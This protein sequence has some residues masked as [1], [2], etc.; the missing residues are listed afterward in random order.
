MSKSPWETLVE[1]QLGYAGFTPELHAAIGR[2]KIAVIGAGGNGAALDLLVRS[3]FSRFVI[4]DPG[5]VND[6]SL[7]R[8]PFN[9]DAIGLPKVE[10]WRKHLRDVNPDCEIRALH[11]GI[12]RTDAAFL[13][14]HLKGVSLILLGTT[15]VEAN[16]VVS[17]IA[18]RLGIR[19]II[20]PVSYGFLVTTTFIHDNGYSY[21][22][23]A[24]FETQDTPLEKIDYAALRGRFL[25]ATSVPGFKD[26]LAPGIWEAVLKGK[27]PTRSCSFLVCLGNAAAAFEAVK[28]VA[29]M[30]A[31]PMP[32]ARLVTIPDVLIYDPW[33]GK[34]YIFNAASGV[35]KE[36]G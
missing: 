20:G 31:L 14:K 5:L 15:D 4:I 12:T 18:S 6:T 1:R 22:K 29:A 33:I 19:T 30:H 16:I 23:L 25:E 10:A 24:G 28:N 2:T 9:R 36:H 32:G 13:E 27:L 3:G 11:T 21:E 8:L 34:S 35:M 17:R 7:N 26:K